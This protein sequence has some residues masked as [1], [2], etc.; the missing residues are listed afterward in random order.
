[1]I[2]AL[3]GTSFGP[4]ILLESIWE[5]FGLRTSR[6][7]TSEEA[8]FD[9]GADVISARVDDRRLELKDEQWAVV[10]PAPRA[11]NRG[12]P[13]LRVIRGRNPPVECW[14]GNAKITCDV[15]RRHTAGEQFLG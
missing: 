6:I 5:I 2:I 8:S 9:P 3:P 13:W 12:R 1:V 11:D 14:N 4:Q 15:T 10:G 7:D